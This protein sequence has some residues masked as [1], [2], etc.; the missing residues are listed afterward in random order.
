MGTGQAAAYSPPRGFAIHPWTNLPV[1]AAN[2]RQ[3]LEKKIF[4]DKITLP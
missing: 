3:G 4:P 1:F 2:F